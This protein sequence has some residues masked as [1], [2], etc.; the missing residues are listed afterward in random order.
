MPTEKEFAEAG[1]ALCDIEDDEGDIATDYEIQISEPDREMRIVHRD[2]DGVIS[3]M[4]LT[5][6]EA[7]TYAHRILRGYDKLEGL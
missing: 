1:I 5:S 6:D 4:I 3:S 2:E 7:Y